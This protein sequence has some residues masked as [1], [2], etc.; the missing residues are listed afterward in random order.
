MIAQDPTIER[1]E[2]FVV[3]EDVFTI[4]YSIE[5][6]IKIMGLGFIMD[7]GSYLRDS[8]N[9][10]DFMIVVSSYPQYFTD[11]NAPSEDGI[12]LSGLRVFR[13]LRPLK[14]VSSIKGLKVLMQALFKA[15]PL[16]GDTL[17]IL[18]FFFAI[19]AIA[20]TNLM[21]GTLKKRCVSI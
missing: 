11:P 10:L 5:M 3:A 8:W 15:M 13:V 17:S 18:C 9:I 16:L 12:S 4:L 6:I 20:G 7:K 21:Q 1:G 14:T 19:M 2:F